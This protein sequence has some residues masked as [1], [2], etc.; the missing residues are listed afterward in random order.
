[1]KKMRSVF[2]I[3]FSVLLC[4]VLCSPAFADGADGAIS[5]EE[6]LSDFQE[7]FHQREL[8]SGQYDDD[9]EADTAEAIQTFADCAEAERDFYEK[10]I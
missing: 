6:F 3:A 8:I 2:C 7:A 10:Y 1:M 4:L 9:M 5:T